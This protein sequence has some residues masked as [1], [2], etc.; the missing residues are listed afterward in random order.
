LTHFN[1][2]G[3]PEGSGTPAFAGLVHWAPNGVQLLGGVQYSLLKQEGR[4][5]LMSLDDSVIGKWRL[6]PVGDT[7]FPANK[8]YQLAGFSD[9]VFDT[10]A[11]LETDRLAL[12]KEIKAI[13]LGKKWC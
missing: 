3:Y 11:L 2:P 5:I 13:K 12:V 7:Q 8:V 10:M 4:I 1:L 9:K 6:V